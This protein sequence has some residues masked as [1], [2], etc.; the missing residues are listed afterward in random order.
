MRSQAP[1]AIVIPCYNHGEFL[2]ETLASIQACDANLY[3]LVI[4]NDGSNDTAT[5][6]LFK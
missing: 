1:I 2:R 6:D 3:E 5:L 4:V